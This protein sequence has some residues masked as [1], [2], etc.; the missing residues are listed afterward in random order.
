MVCCAQGEETTKGRDYS[1]KREGMTQRDLPR[2]P[3]LEQASRVAT[4][5]LA[6]QSGAAPAKLRALC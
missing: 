4:H 2:S 6:K 3:A 1:V 5:A